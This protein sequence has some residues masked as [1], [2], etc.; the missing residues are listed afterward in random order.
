MLA[1]LSRIAFEIPEKQSW[2]QR[3]LLT[4]TTQDQGGINTTK[5]SWRV[6][7]NPCGCVS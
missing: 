3:L 1:E 6:E 4:A 7:G 2:R 5:C